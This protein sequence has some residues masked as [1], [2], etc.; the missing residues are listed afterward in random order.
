MI[1]FYPGTFDPITRGHLDIIRRALKVVPQLVVG[2]G[3]NN[4]K[5]VLFNSVERADL[6][7]NALKETLSKGELA[8]ISVRSY[9]GATVDAAQKIGATVIIKGLRGATDFAY[10]ENMAI[11]NKHLASDIET[12]FLSTD[13]ALRDV[14]SSITK[15]M[16][17]SG[18]APE[19][20]DRYLTPSVKE[21]LLARL[22]KPPHG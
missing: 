2:V 13:N 8:Q 12:V 5:S 11:V 7:N 18:I 19:K 9:S 14:S 6:V 15:E 4:S 22:R 16:V 3:Q 17:A 10:E 21:A 20:F 1:A